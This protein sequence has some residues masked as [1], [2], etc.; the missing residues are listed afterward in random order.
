MGSLAAPRLIGWRA[1]LRLG[2]VSNLPT[3]WSNVIAA[4]T[5][6]G[7]ASGRDVLTAAASMSLLY[8]GGMYLNDAFDRESDAKLRASRPIPSGEVAWATVFIIGFA[9]LAAGIILLAA[10]SAQAGLAG[11]AL[12][13][14]IVIYDFH[15]KGNPLSPLLMGLCR[16]LVYVGAAAVLGAAL[17]TPV[18]IGAGALLLFVAGL[19]LAAK[20][21]SLDRVSNFVPLLLLVAPLALAVPVLA[22]SWLVAV[23]FV[24][25]LAALVYGVALLRRRQPGDVG[26]AIGLL[27]AAIALVDALAAASV[28]ASFAML[29]CFGLFVLTLIFQRYVPGT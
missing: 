14:L 15:H 6:A 24:V 26:R 23:A 11:L 28:G 13:A 12:A 8:V 27:I 5:L 9:L 10:L 20:Q 7:G 2:R 25:L 17:E 1:A 18:L 29:A 3:V 21:E 22:S 16:A 19:T 4:M